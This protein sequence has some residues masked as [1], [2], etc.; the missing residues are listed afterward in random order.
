M[1]IM[2]LNPSD[3]A[4]KLSPEKKYI[5]AV[6]GGVDSVVMLDLL[7]RVAPH[8]MIV[9]HFDHGIRG[10]SDEDALFVGK[11]ADTYQLSIAA[12]REELGSGAS[13]EL[14][15]T[16][17]YTFLREVARE[18][19]AAVVTAHHK[20]DLVET[21]AINL[22]R[23]TGWRGLAVLDTFDLVRPLL[24][25]TKQEIYDY[26]LTRGLEWCEDSTNLQLKYLRNRL[27]A[28]ISQASEGL[29]TD[30]SSLR[31]R[32]V[33][34]KRQI[35]KEVAKI[36]DGFDGE[37]SRYF[38]TSIPASSASEIIREL[39]RLRCGNGLTRLQRDKALLAIKTARPG[40]Q[41]DIGAGII[42][43]CKTK[44]FIV[45]SPQVVLP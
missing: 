3:I 17:R 42:L 10:D 8:K 27:R 13:E 28:K 32:Q 4:S 18:H 23:G 45:E 30:V 33:T 12:R 2:K 15:R 40:T 5:L 26:A 38:F 11:L 25:Y 43:K 36:I 29:L 16:R 1:T 9:A 31:Q 34:K 37:L 6:S 14:A 7:A 41:H 35:T 19:D 44:T 21:V 24:D 22:L 39:L 20:N